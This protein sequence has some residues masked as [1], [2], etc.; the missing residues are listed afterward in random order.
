MKKANVYFF[1]EPTSYLDIKQRLKISRFIRSLADE[2]TAVM[3]IEHDLII[4]DYMTDFVHLMYGKQGAFGIVS[5]LKTTKTGI[6]VY[7]SGYLKEENTRFRD[8]KIKFLKKP[9]V[10]KQSEHKLTE[11]KSLK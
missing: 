5:M 2:K 8:Y 7:L 6:N 1:D 4:L 10:T 3:V 11:W 9:P